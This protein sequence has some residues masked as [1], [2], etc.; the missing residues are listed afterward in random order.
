MKIL[1]VGLKKVYC[2]EPT[3]N[4][5][6]IANLMKENE[7]S[8]VPVCQDSKLIGIVTQRDITVG[9]ISVGLNAWTCQARDFMTTPPVTVTP[10]QSVEEAIQI[11]NQTRLRK[12]PVVDELNRPVGMLTL[13]DIAMAYV[14]R[15]DLIAETMR[16]TTTQIS[17]IAA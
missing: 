10:Q 8:T 6:E 16:N 17:N 4:L 14:E 5:V 12:L 2:V 3:V 11:M 7:M 13:N 15:S 9:C 1:D